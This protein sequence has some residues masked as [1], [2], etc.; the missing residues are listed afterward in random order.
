M[1]ID[2]YIIS[3]SPESARSIALASKLQSQNTSY[4]FLE[5]VDGRKFDLSTFAEYDQDLAR[6][7][8]GRELLGGEIGCYL[9]HLKAAEALLASDAD[10]AIVVEDDAAPRADLADACHVI[11]N[12]LN[13]IDP[14]WML[15]NIG[16]S[17]DKINTDIAS[18]YGSNH[19]LQAAHYFPITTHGLLWS[20]AGAQA[21]VSNHAKIWA[22]V[23]N[24]FR[25]WLTRQGHGYA[26]NPPLVGVTGAES[27][28]APSQNNGKRQ[29][30]G[31]AWHFMLS[32]QKR[33][34]VDKVIA[35]LQ[36]ARFSRALPDRDVSPAE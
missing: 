17:S 28:I 4:Q 21:F 18:I 24:Y 19:Q 10:C 36:R 2:T 20:R 13:E 26:V 29:H 27:E 33:L 34:F 6:R 31:R 9:S 8:M 30:N 7:Y 11:A 32:K 14:D 16:N 3:L 15:V 25:H 12:R 35:A 23:D 5:A 1:R 22:P